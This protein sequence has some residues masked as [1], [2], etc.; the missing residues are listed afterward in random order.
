MIWANA[1]ISGGWVPL[2]DQTVEQWNEILRVNLIGPFL[3]VKHASLQMMKQE[4]GGSIICTASVAGLKANAGGNP[5]SASKAGVISLV[6]TTSY[7]AERHRHP[8]QRHL[9]RPD[10]DRHDAQHVRERARARQGAT[11]SAR[12]IRPS[13]AACRRRSP[14]WACFSPATRR[15]TSTA[16]RSRSTAASPLDALCRQTQAVRDRHM[17]RLAGKVAVITGAGSGIG[18]AT[19]LLFAARRRQG[20]RLRQERRH[21]TRNRRCHPRGGGTAE[22]MTGMPARKPMCRGAR[23]R[24]RKVGPARHR[25]RQCRHS[26]RLGFRCA[27]RRRSAGPKSCAST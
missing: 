19:A 21:R 6:Q 20:P 3:A 25:V 11:R 18:E 1:G 12:S 26:R 10:R 16:R 13:A 7:C 27:T 4:R 2:H 22:A 5:Y 8:R 9:S 17:P 14:R 15:A 24:C 23:C